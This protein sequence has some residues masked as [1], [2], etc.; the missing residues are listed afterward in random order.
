MGVPGETKSFSLV[1]NQFNLGI[2]LAKRGRLKRV[3]GAVE[4]ENLSIY[5]QGGNDVGILRLVP[6]LVDL[7]R[8]LN[9]L[10]NVALDGSDVT[11]V[12]IATNFASLLIV[13]G[14]IWGN[15][16]GDLDISNLQKVGTLIRRMGSEQ[17]SVHAIVFALGFLDIG[18]PLDSQ[19]W[20][21]QGRS[22]VC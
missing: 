11:G 6:S 15:R 4:D 19:C 21:R 13:V 3:L 2:Y 20:P 14:G 1:P 10:D 9:L 17:Q 16:L 22:R 12:A 18:E 7:T 5:T 8:V